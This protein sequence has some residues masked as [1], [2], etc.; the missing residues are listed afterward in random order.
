MSSLARPGGK[1]LDLRVW[2]QPSDVVIR[3]QRAESPNTGQDS[4]GRKTQILEP[5]AGQAGSDP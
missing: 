4:W 3:G 5:S 2:A 1:V